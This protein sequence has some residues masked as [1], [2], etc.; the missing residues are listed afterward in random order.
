MSR[1]L[2]KDRTADSPEVSG[3]RGRGSKTALA[4]DTLYCI[5]NDLQTAPTVVFSHCLWTRSLARPSLGLRH[6]VS[7]KSAITVPPGAQDCVLAVCDESCCEG[8]Q[9]HSTLCRFVCHLCTG[10]MVISVH[11]QI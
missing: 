1:G 3:G 7:K 8:T 6:W 2:P 4:T 5:I 11:F 9:K 10:A